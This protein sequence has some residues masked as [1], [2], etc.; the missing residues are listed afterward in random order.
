[1]CL[2]C[3]KTVRTVENE[4]CR[5]RVAKSFGCLDPGIAARRHRAFIVDPTVAVDA[6]G[7]CKGRRFRLDHGRVTAPVSCSLDVA[8][9]SDLLSPGCASN[10]KCGARL[11]ADWLKLVEIH[12]DAGVGAH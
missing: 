1:M 12:G 2:R 7:L 9:S 4:K 11:D 8:C 3:A 5:P 6:F 10:A